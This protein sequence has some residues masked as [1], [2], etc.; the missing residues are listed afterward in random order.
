[1]EP[2]DRVNCFLFSSHSNQME[3]VFDE[4]ENISMDL[5]LSIELVVKKYLDQMAE[6]T[7]QINTCQSEDELSLL[8]L[9]F[10]AIH[11]ITEAVCHLKNRL[12]TNRVEIKQLINQNTF[13]YKAKQMGLFHDAALSELCL[14][15]KKQTL[16]HAFCSTDKKNKKLEKNTKKLENDTVSAKLKKENLIFI[17]LTTDSNIEKTSN[18]Q[19]KRKISHA[20]PI[21]KRRKKR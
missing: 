3:L 4:E 8:K 10:E 2:L 16:K 9:K 5:Q 11:N 1:M 18:D 14:E 7:S 6:M 15:E 17:D 21:S 13:E 20:Y 19:N 12:D